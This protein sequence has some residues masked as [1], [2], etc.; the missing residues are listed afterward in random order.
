[1][2]RS[3]VAKR[4][5]RAGDERRLICEVADD[6]LERLFRLRVSECLVTRTHPHQRFRANGAR[7]RG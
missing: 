5:S 3:E 1:V 6:A 4:C 2:R 7:L